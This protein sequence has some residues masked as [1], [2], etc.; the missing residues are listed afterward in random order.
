M[1]SKITN[2]QVEQQIQRFVQALGEAWE[3]PFVWGN[4]KSLVKEA[5]RRIDQNFLLEIQFNR[6]RQ[7]DG[8]KETE[9]ERPA[10]A[11]LQ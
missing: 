6:Q 7:K 11:A 2:Q 1:T 9:V 8:D 10:D 5:V 3:P 4:V